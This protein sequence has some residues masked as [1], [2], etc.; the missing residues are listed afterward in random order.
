MVAVPDFPSRQ[1]R[2][3]Y[4]S[5]TETQTAGEFAADTAEHQLE[6]LH[7]VGLYRHLHCLDGETVNVSYWLERCK[8][9]D[10]DRPF[11]EFSVGRGLLP[12]ATATVISKAWT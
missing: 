5:A 8:A 12:T 1:E 3:V 6:V 4:R 7:D 9:C 10:V 11:K 2:P